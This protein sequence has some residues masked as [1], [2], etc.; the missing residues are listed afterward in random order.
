[1]LQPQLG[2]PIGGKLNSVSWFDWRNLHNVPRTPVKPRHSCQ[3]GSHTHCYL[4]R[5][6][7]LKDVVAHE[8]TTIYFVD[9]TPRD[10]IHKGH[11]P[12]RLPPCAPALFPGLVWWP[13]IQLLQPMGNGEGFVMSAFFAYAV[14]P[15]TISKVRPVVVTLFEFLPGFFQGLLPWLVLEQLP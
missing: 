14:G 10:M 13:L 7:L 6:S 5:D 1:M 15:D 11:M 2:C 12:P 8:C 3:R 9:H 4:C